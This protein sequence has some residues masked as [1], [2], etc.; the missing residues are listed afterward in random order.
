LRG[1]I[2]GEGW[3][4]EEGRGEGVMEWGGCCLQ[5]LGDHRPCN[6][7]PT[8]AIELGRKGSSSPV[9]TARQLG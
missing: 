7:Q 8:K 6:K 4:R 2:E 5:L 1:G 3:E 9:L